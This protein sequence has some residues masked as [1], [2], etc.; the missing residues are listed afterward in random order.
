M[1]KNLIMFVIKSK[2]KLLKTK[3]DEFDSHFK[4][5]LD[6]GFINFHHYQMM[7]SY[8]HSLSPLER[9]KILSYSKVN[10]L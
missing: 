1:F 10:Y 7:K 9:S 4:C 6:Q 3:N 2:S 5:F 8:F